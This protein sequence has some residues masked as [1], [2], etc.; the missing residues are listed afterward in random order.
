M[1]A[2]Q[3]GILQNY[4]ANR[5][6]GHLDTAFTNTQSQEQTRTQILNRFAV[7]S[8]NLWVSFDRITTQSTVGVQINVQLGSTLVLQQ[9]GYGLHPS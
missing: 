9:E 7:L 2:I 3:G 4:T 1:L 6:Y 8:T 5:L